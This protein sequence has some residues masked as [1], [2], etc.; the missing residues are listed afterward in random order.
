MNDLF[1]VAIEIRGVAQEY[2]EERDDLTI[3]QRA[4]LIDICEVD[5]IE[6]NAYCIMQW[7]KATE[8]TY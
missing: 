8:L 7:W 3:G 4:L 1:S 6:A 2:I 5:L